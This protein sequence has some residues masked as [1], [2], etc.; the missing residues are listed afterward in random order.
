MCLVERNQKCHSGILVSKAGTLLEIRTVKLT[1]AEP[2]DELGHWPLCHFSHYF[3]DRFG[4][5]IGSECS[6]CGRA[7]TGGW[8]HL[9]GDLVAFRTVTVRVKLRFAVRVCERLLYR[10]RRRVRERM[11]DA[12]ACTRQGRFPWILYAVAIEIFERRDIGP[13]DTGDA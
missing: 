5:R 11:G 2:H 13:I 1:L 3:V 9:H 4:D 6:R 8:R 12:H 10:G 7:V